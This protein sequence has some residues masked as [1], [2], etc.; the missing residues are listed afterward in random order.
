MKQ[1]AL[2]HEKE[3]DQSPHVAVTVPGM[4]TFIGEFAD[5]C[6]G[7]TLCG[8]ASTSLSVSIS[9]RH[10]QSVRLFIEPLQER[11]RFSLQA[12]K[13]RR[14][15][16]WANY[17]KGILSVLNNSDYKVGGFNLTFSGDLLLGEGSVVQSAMTL[18]ATLAINALFHPTITASESAI[19]SYT[20][21]SSFAGVDCR[22][23]MF[24]AM[25]TAKKNTL[26]LYDIQQLSYK[27]IPFNIAKLEYVPLIVESKISNQALQEELQLRK[28]EAL[29]AFEKIKQQFPSRQIRELSDQEIKE[30]ATSL[31]EEEKRM[32]I[33]VL[34]ESR[35]AKEAATL[36][37]Q[38]DMV[39]YGKV[40]SRVQSGLRD[41]F[42]VTCPEI[43]W[44]SKRA[45]E[46]SGSLGAT[47]IT[48]GFSGTMLVLLSQ[49]AVSLYTTRMEEYEHIFGFRPRVRVY[50]PAGPYEIFTYNR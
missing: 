30:S 41:D 23:V 33:F 10:D 45:L 46:T 38:K 15:D 14:E 3:F 21:L 32:S 37:E 28:D 4:Y 49:D 20:A 5:L 42:E 35:L 8:P 19:M 47:M 29:E 34:N 7:Y 6:K 26:L 17:V 40:L 50:Q 25:L 13:Y 18:A 44:L 39:Q 11:K 43:D 48:T 36:L 9:P 27:E 24:L 2:L 31:D 22:L 16:R 12:I 1:L